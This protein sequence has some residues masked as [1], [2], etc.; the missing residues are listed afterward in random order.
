MDKLFA[1]ASTA[2]WWLGV[3]V[4]GILINWTSSLL[5]K[6][7]GTVTQKLPKWL[8]NK[9]KKARAAALARAADYA[10]NP[11]RRPMYVARAV[12][13]YVVGIQMLCMI[14]LGSFSVVAVKGA[15]SL[16]F[17]PVMLVAGACAIALCSIGAI[18]FDTIRSG[19]MLAI[20]QRMNLE[21]GEA[22]L[23]GD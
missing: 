21:A 23:G 8:Q 6:L 22:S 17:L 7:G 11:E 5:Q 20:R 18:N 13:G 10:N 2:N 1:D 16:I 12:V 15:V 4:V 19:S 3:V 14:T 9:S